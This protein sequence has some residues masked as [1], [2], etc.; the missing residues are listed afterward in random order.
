MFDLF[1]TQ[2]ETIGQERSNY[3]SFLKKEIANQE[4]FFMDMHLLKLIANKISIPQDIVTFFAQEN[5]QIFFEFSMKQQKNHTSFFNKL[6][7][8]DPKKQIQLQQTNKYRKMLFET[9]AN[10]L[11]YEPHAAFLFEIA[12]INIASSFIREF[13]QNETSN[14][15]KKELVFMKKVVEFI[16]DLRSELSKSFTLPIEFLE[17]LIDQI[18][19]ASTSLHPLSDFEPLFLSVGYPLSLFEQI[20]SI[21]LNYLS[22]QQIEELCNSINSVALLTKEDLKKCGFSKF[23]FPSANDLNILIKNLTKQAERSEIQLIK[24]D[25]ELSLID[26]RVSEQTKRVIKEKTHL[27]SNTIDGK[28]KKPLL[29]A[30]YN[31]SETLSN[32]EKICLDYIWHLKDFAKKSYNLSQKIESNRS[33]Q[34]MNKDFLEEFLNQ[35][36][37]RNRS[38]ISKLGIEFLRFSP[39]LNIASS[40]IEKTVIQK[41]ILLY[42]KAERKEIKHPEKTRELLATYSELGKTKFH[43]NV[44]KILTE[45]KRTGEKLLLPL[46]L[47]TILQKNIR[48]WPISTNITSMSQSQLQNE[49]NFFGLYA[50]PK[51]KFLHFSQTGQVRTKGSTVS[52]KMYDE[53]AAVMEKRF[54]KVVA[55]LIYDIRGS[56]FMTL[57]L[58]NAERE[59]MIIKYFHTTMAKIAKKFGAFL[60]K[61]I[62]DGGI[63]WFGNNSKD[64]YNSI[65]RESMTKK[66]KKLR[67]SLLSEEGLF[68]QSSHDSS[69]KAI[70]C[71]IAMVKAAEKFIKDNYVKYRDWFSDIKERELLVEGTTYALLP[72][73]FRSLFRLG[74]GVSSGLP[75]SDIA[76]GPNAFGDPD[77]RGLLVNEAKFLSE[78]RNPENSVILVDHDTVFNSL[79]NT[80]KFTLGNIDLAISDKDEMITKVAQIVKKKLE[81][82]ELNFYTKNFIAEPYEILS[83]ETFET[84]KYTPVPLNLDE[85]GLLYNKKGEQVK[86]VYQVRFT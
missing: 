57:K 69:E 38:T 26:H 44:R 46:L 20:H 5:C 48:Q 27:I 81:G 66:F 35:Q 43:P 50:I 82:G 23:S 16:R 70:L 24:N 84:L 67:H 1:L 45:Y 49:A 58:H 86:I 2:I 28:N 59:Q 78:G 4:T 51:G 32:I 64:L 73:M 71:A 53:L 9:Y 25:K 76:I 40:K 13:L 80:S 52:K 14:K 29:E 37:Y 31:I 7:R 75:S 22:H 79:L 39:L 85:N 54:R 18:T 47:N 77:L 56:S 8:L 72:P 36:I 34:R 17:S 3:I 6:Y 11:K 60:L 10:V 83:L 63:I 19:Y 65:Y 61:D 15:L 12:Y 74:I 55:V 68:L 62:G 21:L 42:N 30:S 41:T 33:L